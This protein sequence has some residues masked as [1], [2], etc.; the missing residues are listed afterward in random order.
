MPRSTT[1]RRIAVACG[2]ALVLSAYGMSTTPAFAK[3]TRPTVAIAT[4]TG[5]GKVLVDS[6]GRTLYTFTNDG[7]AV[8]CSGEC[9]AAWPPLVVKSGSTLKS[10]RGVTRLGV[11]SAS[12]QI[13]QDGLPLY[14]FAG[15]SKVGQANGDGITSFGGTWH[16]AR[17]ARTRAG[18]TPPT[19]PKT[20][21]SM[22]G[23]GY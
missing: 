12:H 6:K 20:S 15:D 8:P 22:G 7:Q 1:L 19:A 2:A 9:A 17:T 23:Y 10:G 18:S 11:A 14:R 5:V 13:T 16:V 3:S 21:S 4:I